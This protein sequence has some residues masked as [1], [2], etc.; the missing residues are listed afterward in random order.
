MTGPGSP[1]PQYRTSGQVKAVSLRVLFV[2]LT[3]LPLGMFSWAAMLRIAIL[4]R[5]RLDWVLFCAVLVLSVVPLALIGSTSSEDD[6]QMDVGMTLLL[7]LAFGVTSYYLV[8]DIR[9]HDAG[10]SPHLPAPPSPYGPPQLFAAPFPAPS[11]GYPPEQ[12]PHRFPQE[13]PPPPPPSRPAPQRID[14]VRAELD[15]L[16]HYL[17]KEDGR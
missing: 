12:P 15:E 3:L 9:L 16:S 17:R 2:A 5:R 14:R 7:L 4:R 11:Y 6:W 10:A 8:V 1:P 13:Q